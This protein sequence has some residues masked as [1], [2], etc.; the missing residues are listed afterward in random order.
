MAKN[1]VATVVKLNAVQLDT[2]NRLMASMNGKAYVHADIVDSEFKTNVIN[3]LYTA[4]VI[5]DYRNTRHV[6][7]T[8][9]QVELLVRKPR[10]PKEVG[11]NVAEQPRQTRKQPTETV[12]A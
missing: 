2:Y 8:G 4:G 3:G 9:V 12:A 7:P 1:T 11:E 10:A 5:K 6:M